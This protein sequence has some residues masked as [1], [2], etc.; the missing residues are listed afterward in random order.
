MGIH[1]RTGARP[2]LRHSLVH[3]EWWL[4]GSLVALINSHAYVLGV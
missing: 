3:R 4:M 2:L 1:D